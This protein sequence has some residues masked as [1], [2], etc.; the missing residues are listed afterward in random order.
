MSE[1]DETKTE[2]LRLLSEIRTA[3]GFEPLEDPE[4]SA[5]LPL[6]VSGAL[7]YDPKKQTLE[8]RLS[9]PLEL[10]NGELVEYVSFREASASDLE[11]IRG[12]TSIG[13]QGMSLGDFISMTVRV[14]VK[15]SDITTVVA[16]RIKA[17]DIDALKEVMTELG[18]FGR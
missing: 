15:T 16:D 7:L 1:A 5:L 10:K 17:R 6:L 11:Y 8:Y 2:A 14:L 18:F 13:G 4:T 3:F 12:G 9:S